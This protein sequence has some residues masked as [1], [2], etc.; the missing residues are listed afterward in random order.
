LLLLSLEE[1]RRRLWLAQVFRS[2]G[3]EL[4]IW[5]VDRLKDDDHTQ[6][7]G[8]RIEGIEMMEE[9]EEIL[10]DLV[11]RRKMDDPSLKMDDPRQASE[12]KEG[13]LMCRALKCCNIFAWVF[14]QALPTCPNPTL[15][16]QKLEACAVRIVS[17]ASRQNKGPSKRMIHH[18]RYSSKAFEAWIRATRQVEN[19]LRWIASSKERSKSIALPV[20]ALESGRSVGIMHLQGLMI[21]ARAFPH[22][23][24][25]GPVLSGVAR[26]L[27]HQDKTATEGRDETEWFESDADF[28]L[29]FQVFSRAVP[30]PRDVDTLDELHRLMDQDAIRDS[31]LHRC[32]QFLDASEPTK[33]CVCCSRLLSA[34]RTFTRRRPKDKHCI[35]S[36]WFQYEP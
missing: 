17:L 30:R 4:F 10:F 24:D 3:L 13:G 7:R 33:N 15:S 12:L 19:V 2:V 22:I 32:N 5:A 26:F 16:S 11:P 36:G 35:Q 23:L 25:I 6:S 14:E 18:D 34:L 1:K 20:I 21:V 9:M 27:S 29:P 28:H 31:S 8:K